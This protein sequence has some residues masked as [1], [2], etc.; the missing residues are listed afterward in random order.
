L[1]SGYRASILNLQHGLSPLS[2]TGAGCGESSVCAFLDNIPLKLGKCL[3]D[4]ENEFPAAGGGVDVLCQALKADVSTVQIG[5]PLDEI[6]EGSATSRSSRQTT[7]VSPP[8]V[9]AL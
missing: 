7:R 2:A 3:E 1:A 5:E 4:M 8:R 6:F 9:I